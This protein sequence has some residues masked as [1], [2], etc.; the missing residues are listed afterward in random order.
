MLIPSIVEDNPADGWTGFFLR[1]PILKKHTIVILSVA[2]K[3]DCNNTPFDMI[4]CAEKNRPIRFLHPIG[5][6]NYKTR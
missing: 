5:W 2:K 6:L 1:I 3:L 4:C